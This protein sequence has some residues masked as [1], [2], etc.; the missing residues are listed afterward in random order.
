[1][2]LNGIATT[3]SYVDSKPEPSIRHWAMKK[4]E[5]TPF[6]LAFLDVMFCGFGAVVLLV[7]I[8]NGQVLQKR[9][10]KK[11][12]LEGELKRVTALYEFARVN[13]ANL[14]SDVAKTEIREGE[15]E[16]QARQL[17][18][19]IQ[20]TRQQTEEA[21]KSAR[22]QGREIKAI[23]RQKEALENAKKLLESR[24]TITA[25]PSGRMVGFTGDGR[26]QYLTGLK[27]GG[28]RTLILIDASASMLDE[29]IVNIVRRKLMNAESR[30][31]APKWSR[32]VRSLHWLVANLQSK[33][34]FQVYYFNTE[35]HPVIADTDGQWL[36]CS[37]ANRLNDAIA[38]VRQLAPEKGTSLHQ[39]FA[40][41]RKLKP[42]PD[43]IILLTDGLPTQGSRATGA[44]TISAKD[45]LK[46]FESAIA[47]L[48]SGIPINTLLFP[49]EGDPTAAEAFWRLAIATGGSFITPSRNWP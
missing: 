38:S 10:E 1:M 34:K 26:R 29:T 32:V 39:A 15:L 20:Q 41:A 46:L 21:K 6:N 45:R 16:G 44:N 49:L 48:S 13:L 40:V 11:E 4:R 31:Q 36:S 27:L 3:C 12:D 43:S 17:L 8:L 47:R 9:E 5:S 30:R 35:A 7:M 22:E 19:N 2:A 28:D 18:E 25:K 42:K 37:D 23:E 24:K 33:K 14:Q